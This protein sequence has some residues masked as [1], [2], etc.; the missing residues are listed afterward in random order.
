ME[1]PFPHASDESTMPLLD[2]LRELKKRVVLSGIAVIAGFAVCMLFAEDIYA[3]LAAP[4]IEALAEREGGGNMTIIA[5]LEGVM[6]WLRVGFF[7]GLVLAFPVIAYQVWLFVAP[8]L[9]QN[10]KRTVAPLVFCSV[11]LMLLGAAFGYYVIFRFGF[12]FF[13]SIMSSGAEANISL[14]SYFS[15]SLKLMVGLGLCFQ[16]PVVIYFCARMGWLDA[17]DMVEKFRYG[18]VIIFLISAIMTPPDPLTQMLMSGPLSFL[19]AV[20]IGVAHLF[21]T[22][23]R[24]DG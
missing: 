1:Q 6:T 23:E 16:L 13:L 17:R 20:S 12:P 24:E 19:Y 2:H 9:H 8:G 21:S 3:F 10:E 4:M 15:T 5:P 11:L 14:A 22:K 7:G 18:I